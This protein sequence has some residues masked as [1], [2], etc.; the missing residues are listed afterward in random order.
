MENKNVIIIGA[1]PAGISTALYT[2]GGN[3]DTTVISLDGGSLWKTKKIENFYGQE[4]TLSGEELYKRGIDGAK[5]RG[6]KFVTTEVLSIGYGMNGFFEVITP[7]KNHKASS[8][9]LATGVQRKKP[10]IG[11]IEA[12]EGKGVSYCAVCDAM[13]FKNKRVAVLGNAKYALHE[14][15]TLKNVTSSITLL[16][17]GEE[18]DITGMEISDKKINALFGDTVLRGVTYEDGST[19]EFDGLFIALGTAGSADLAKKAGI[20][21]ENGNIVTDENGATNIPGIYAV[22]D[23][24]GGILQISKAVYDGTKAGL[25]VIKY[26]KGK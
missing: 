13:F 17:N 5:N 7:E 4:K 22:G 23:C 14:A 1:G 2:A 16:T 26:L 24:T 10:N 9:V 25:S 19:A 8:V 20:L 6:V 18:T 11:N 12:F 21:T 15:E 3:I